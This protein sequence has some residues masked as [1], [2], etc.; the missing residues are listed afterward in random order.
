MVR[1]R[2]RVTLCHAR[3]GATMRSVPTAA[4]TMSSVYT[5]AVCMR[6]SS[7]PRCCL[8]AWSWARVAGLCLPTKWLNSKRKRARRIML[9]R[10]A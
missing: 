10:R 1:P 6:A 5:N 4:S 9:R 3:R 2:V 8:R 7:S